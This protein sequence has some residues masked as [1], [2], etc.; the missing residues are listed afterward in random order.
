MPGPDAGPPDAGTGVGGAVGADVAPGGS[1]VGAAVGSDGGVV[2][3]GVAE[4]GT[5]VPAGGE[6]VADGGAGGEHMFGERFSTTH[7]L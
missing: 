1:G 7:A 2:G 4:P 6:G 5:G 3:S